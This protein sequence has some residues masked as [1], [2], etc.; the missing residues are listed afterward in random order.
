[1][2]KTIKDIDLKCKYEGYIWMSDQKEPKPFNLECIPQD[3]LFSTN[4]FVIEALLVDKKAKKSYSI[5]YVDG[6]HIVKQYDVD[7]N[8]LL[9]NI[10]YIAKRIDGHS[11]LLFFQRWKK[12][13][14][15]DGLCAGMPT[16]VPSDMVFVGFE[17]SK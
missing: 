14:D 5:R 12:E 10:R 16:L 1:M 4:P 3:M 17:S 6:K 9:G 13:E 15:K 2:E 7:E 11:K 8:E